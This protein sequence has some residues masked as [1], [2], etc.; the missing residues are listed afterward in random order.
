[1]G[2]SNLS[3]HTSVHKALGGGRVADV[4][5]WRR[6][7]GGAMLLVWATTMWYLFEIAGYNFLSFVANVLLLNVVILFFW[8]KS[9]SL[10]NRPLPPIPNMEISER[11][12]G[13]VSDE[14]HGWINGVLAVAHDIT[15]GRNFKLFIKVSVG[16]WFVS[17]IGSLI[18]FL[19]LLYIGV[20]LILSVPFVYEKYQHQINEKLSVTDR[21]I[22]A[23]FRK[24]DEKVFSKLPFSSNKEKKMQ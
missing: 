2:D 9:A 15:I 19:T 18:N 20:I 22:Q 6:W 7:G 21:T 10:L 17:F 14:L 16:L 8:A 1:M 13:M 12:I 4:L 11:T 24:I 23:Q 3:H 5:L